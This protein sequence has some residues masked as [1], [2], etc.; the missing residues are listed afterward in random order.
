MKLQVLLHPQLRNP[1]G[2]ENAKQILQSLGIHPTAAGA[3]SISAE[4]DNEAFRSV[5]GIP[6]PE[7]SSAG[8]VSNETLPVPESLKDYV[9]SISIAPRHIYMNS[10]RP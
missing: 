2:V 10:S 4:V 3:A 6:P 8:V 5:F 9:A 1:S 7:D